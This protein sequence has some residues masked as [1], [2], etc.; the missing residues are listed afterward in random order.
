MKSWELLLWF[1][2]LSFL[3]GLKNK[4]GIAIGARC[5]RGQPFSSSFFLPSK[6]VWWILPGGAQNP[7]SAG[8]SPQ[9]KLMEAN[10]MSVRLVLS[11]VCMCF[12]KWLWPYRLGSQGLLQPGKWGLAGPCL[13]SCIAEVLEWHATQCL[14]HCPY[15]RRVPLEPSLHQS[16]AVL[17]C[18]LF[19][20][21]RTMK[22]GGECRATE[23]ASWK[24]F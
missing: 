10:S 3:L 4:N 20:E 18:I 11:L 12:L 21:L 13:P 19:G 2:D 15:K 17:F 1:P 7:G 9:Q 14:S 22:G 5:S 8:L 16:M 6:Q 24:A 23:V